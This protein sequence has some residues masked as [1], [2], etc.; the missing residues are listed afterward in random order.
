MSAQSIQ[1]KLDVAHKKISNKLGYKYTL[2]R[3]LHNVDVLDD[4]NIVGD[5]L[6]TFTMSD[7]YTKALSW[8][9]PVYTAYTNA[10]IV[11]E[12]DFLW[13]E[14]EGRTFLVLSRQP[15]QPVLILEMPDRID[16]QSVGYGDD[17]DGFSPSAT[18][19]TARNLPANISYEASGFGGMTPARSVGTA[20][21]RSA[22]IY[23][24]LPKSAMLMGK[25]VLTGDGFR[26]DI[27]NYDYSMVGNAVTF[28][29][30]EFQSPQ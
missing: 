11:Q 27:T 23:T 10:A 14:D 17:G 9:L 13:S 1:R 15:H 25:T 7:G 3:P 28:T 20:G 26:G 24:S 22:N 5:V 30:Q 19:Y 2:Y 29:A 16:I 12:G 18:T 6:L 21:I 8:E 4:S